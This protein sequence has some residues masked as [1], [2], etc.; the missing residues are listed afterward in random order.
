MK[1]ILLHGVESQFVFKCFASYPRDSIK[2][3]QVSIEFL[4][5]SRVSP[6]YSQVAIYFLSSLLSINL[7]GT[8]LPVTRN[9]VAH[10]HI[11]NCE[12]YYSSHASTPCCKRHYISCD[13]ETYHA[14]LYEHLYLTR[15]ELLEIYS[16]F[17]LL[18]QWS[19]Y[20]TTS[21]ILTEIGN[22]TMLAIVRNVKRAYRWKRWN[23]FFFMIN[24][25]VLVFIRQIKCVTSCS[26][27]S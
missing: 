9:T 2:F 3:V 18:P 20:G 14:I 25:N 27:R 22:G 24:W 17:N 23:M 19:T 21:I 15:E 10:L 12:L 6:S 13:I 7:Y 26:V 5:K 16:I 11:A 4:R 1:N 8:R